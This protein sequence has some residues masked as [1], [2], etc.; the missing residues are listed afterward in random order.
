[1]FLGRVYFN[2]KSK[3]DILKKRN[4]Q[5]KNR[6]KQNKT[7]PLLFSFLWTTLVIRFVTVIRTTPKQKL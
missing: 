3:G 2:G 6:A 5:T 1:M 7:K 4:K